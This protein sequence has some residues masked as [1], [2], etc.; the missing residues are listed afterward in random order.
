MGGQIIAFP[1]SIATPKGKINAK[2]YEGIS[3]DQIHSIAQALFPAEFAIF[4]NDNASI[5]T[6]GI[7]QRNYTSSLACTIA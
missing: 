3:S 6:A 7:V 5:Q 1:E 4:Q 2:V